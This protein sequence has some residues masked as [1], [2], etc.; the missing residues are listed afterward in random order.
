MFPAPFP[1]NVGG[2]GFAGVR[3]RRANQAKLKSVGAGFI[4]PSKA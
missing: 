1:W 2:N 4:C 3:W